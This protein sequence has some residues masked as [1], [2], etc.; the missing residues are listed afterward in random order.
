LSNA[1]SQVQTL[2]ARKFKPTSIV[3]WMRVVLA[4]VAG[5]ANQFLHIDQVSFGDFA[6]FIGIGLGIVIYALSIVIVQRVLH[7]GEVEMKGK[8]RYITLGGGTFIVLWIV[9]SIFLY[10]VLG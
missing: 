8:N 1:Q 3:Y 6:V 5:F 7:F 10:T 2:P 9:V 4:V